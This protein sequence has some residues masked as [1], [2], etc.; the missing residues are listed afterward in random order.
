[1]PSAWVSDG[2]HAAA[3]WRLATASI[4]IRLENAIRVMKPISEPSS[5]PCEYSG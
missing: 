5:G 2:N 3:Y 4:A 1:M